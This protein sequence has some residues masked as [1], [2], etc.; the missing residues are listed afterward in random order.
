MPNTTNLLLLNT[1][2]KKIFPLF[3]FFL[4]FTNVALANPIKAIALKEVSYTKND[5]EYV[6]HQ[7]IKGCVGESGEVGIYTADNQNFYLIDGARQI[8]FLEKSPSYK[9][10][11]T[12]NFEGYQHTSVE[13]QGAPG[14]DVALSIY[15][16]LYP[17]NSNKMAVAIIK[18]EFETYSGGGR[19]YKTADFL[20]LKNNGSYSV[21]LKSV[22]FY[23]DEMI[24]ACFSEEEYRNNPHCHDESMSVLSIKYHDDKKPYYRW[25][26]RYTDTIWEQGVSE[27]MK[28]I[29]KHK[30]TFV[31]PYQQENN[32]Q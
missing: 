3:S 21:A 12:W 24:R 11:T 14:A 23:M 32:Q 28:R 4:L 16:A 18:T 2:M 9:V 25:E 15:P 27:K 8:V 29:K 13:P 30:P 6:C 10:K 5:L 26:L 1:V 22:P 19:T 17:L 31:I 7:L 20:E